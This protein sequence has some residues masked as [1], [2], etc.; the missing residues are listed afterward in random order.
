M[1]TKSG[2]PGPSGF[3]QE[4]LQRLRFL[5]NEIAHGIHRPEG[6]VI[7]QQLQQLGVSVPT[8]DMQWFVADLLRGMHWHGEHYVPPVVVDVVRHC[9]E[10]SRAKLLLDPWAGVGVLA[11][12][13]KD[14]TQAAHCIA[15][16]S[17]PGTLALAR[18]LV[19][20]VDWR[21]TEITDPLA[22]LHEISEPVDIAV[23]VP[24]MGMKAQEPIEVGTSNQS[25]NRTRDVGQALLAACALRLAPD[26]VALF[27][28][29]AGSLLSSDSIF[30]RLPSLGLGI[31]A[32]L[33]MPA[34]SFAPYANISSY[35]VIVRRQ[36]QA[37][38]FVAR[39]SQDPQTNLQVLANLREGRTGGAVEMGRMLP[40][41]EFRGLEEIRLRE[42]LRQAEGRFGSAAVHLGDIAFA[43]TIGRPG[44]S[45]SF[46][47]TDNAVFV[48]LVG[49]S[50]VVT[51]KDEMTLKA[52]NYAQVAIDPR[53]SDARFVARFLN[54]ELGR[55]IRDANKSG[56]VIPKLNST[57]V[58]ELR[59]FVPPLATQQRV[60]EVMARITAEGNTVLSLQSELSNLS[61]DLWAGPAQLEDVKGR[62]REFSKRMQAGAATHA[63][64]TLDQWFESLPFPLASILRAWQ[65][66]PSQDHKTKQE[67]LL[68]FFEAT[69][70]FFSVILLSA[71]ASRTEMFAAH[72]QKLKEAWSKQHLTLEH[73]TFGTWKVV[74]EYLAKQTRALA[75]GDSESRTLCRDLFADESL[76]LADML[77]RKELSSILSA[78]NKMR[79]DWSGHGGVLG[80]G[81]AS[82]RNQVLLT[83]LQKLRDAMSDGWSQIQ[84]VRALGCQPRRGVFDNEVAVMMGSNSEFLKESRTMSTWLDV[85]RLYI[86]SKNSGRALCLLPL[87][88][89]GPSPAS[90]K[91]ACYFF[92]R[93]DED[94]VRFVSYHYADQPERKGQFAE[95]SEAIRLLTEDVQ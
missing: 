22:C 69:A 74:V 27:V 93:V 24:P 8:E 40:V 33:E 1:N 87:V 9:L 54:S 77:G 38:M 17:S 76:T 10:G 6:E 51:S 85:E 67:H 91:N 55:K 72:R 2:P 84:L 4:L 62:L 68:H 59:I 43:T 56:T 5:R 30:R 73:A 81:E 70:E 14:A 41:G 52:Q 92:N 75:S 80:P 61:R 48:P 37:Q 7:A 94:G 35:L 79:N 16:A 12:A 86:V 31:Q 28:L 20:Q 83:E 58:Q 11:A 47:A 21:L 3:N 57:G 49:I 19:P 89:V 44:E 29:P 64:A 46:P 36:P 95:T 66:T 25:A 88:N 39:L 53:R 18:A 82:L 78:T 26:G 45:F 34:G 63:T 23:C 65:A 32:A 13:A 42:Q 71:F 90:A 15:Y 50:D 60:L